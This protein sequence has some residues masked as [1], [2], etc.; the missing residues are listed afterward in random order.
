M[1]RRRSRP[2]PDDRV[3][4][5]FDEFPKPLTPIRSWPW[6]RWSPSQRVWVVARIALG[7]L[8]TAA[9]GISALVLVLGLGP[10]AYST[11]FWRRI[12][13]G[14]LQSIHAGSNQ[15]YIEQQLGVPAIVKQVSVSPRLTEEIYFRRDHLVM[16]ITN[17]ARETVVFS[18]LSCDPRFQPEFQTPGASNIVLQRE[19]LAEAEFLPGEGSSADASD[20]GASR[21]LTYLPPLTGSSPDRLVEEGAASGSNATRARRYFLGVNGVCADTPVLGDVDTLSYVGSPE[22]APEGVHTLRSRTAANFY[23]EVTLESTLNE[24]GAL[25]PMDE[26]YR[27]RSEISVDLSPHSFDLPRN[28]VRRSGTQ[29]FG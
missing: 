2:T 23:A 13:Y 15:E 7:F 24:L 6:R 9:G 19:P 10:Q 14:L 21:S 27:P 26:D 28:Q 1:V 20:F 18:V 12:E 5:V 11:L 22:R 25:N 17:E 16:T 29:T 3:G 8:V 4:D